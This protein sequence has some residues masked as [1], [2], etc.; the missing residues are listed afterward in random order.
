[1]PA[2][3]DDLA[4]LARSFGL[5]AAEAR[6]SRDASKVQLLASTGLQ[7]QGFNNPPH[8]EDVERK[9][10]ADLT[11]PPVAYFFNSLLDWHFRPTAF[12]APVQGIERVG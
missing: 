11:A 5:C 12:T 3:S 7:A 10:E 6:P 1:M 4:L 2:F 9:H 8:A